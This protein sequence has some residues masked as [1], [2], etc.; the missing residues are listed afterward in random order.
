MQFPSFR[1]S[2]AGLAAG[3]FATASLIMAGHA[4][5]KDCGAAAT[6]DHGAFALEGLKSELMVTALACGQQERYNAFVM[7]FRPILLANEHTL[8]AYFRRTYGAR[9]A[10]LR[11]DYVTQLAD[12]QSLQGGKQGTLFCTQRTPMFDEVNVL[13][14]G[15]DLIHYA[16]AK[17]ITQPPSYEQACQGSVTH[18]FHRIMRT[19]RRH[20]RHGRTHRK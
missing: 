13:Q 5:A 20:A 4:S 14:N 19:A 18:T 10:K 12:V 1:F 9:G 6:A 7:K 15:P 17:A 3:L 16:E 8:D 11:D 2:P